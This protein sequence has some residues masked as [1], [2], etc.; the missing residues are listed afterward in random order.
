V[1]WGRSCEVFLLRGGETAA[2]HP[3]LGMDPRITI[4]L[5]REGEGFIKSAKKIANYGVGGAQGWG[6]TICALS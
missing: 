3:L 6:N 4:F 5:P 1:K 2:R